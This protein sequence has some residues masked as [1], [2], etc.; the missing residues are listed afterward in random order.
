MNS[1]KNFN[2]DLES[3]MNKIVE[4]LEKFSTDKEESNSKINSIETF[5]SNLESKMNTIL[6]SLDKYNS[7][8]DRKRLKKERKKNLKE[9]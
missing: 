4:R 6:E 7:Y 5:N 3:K 8:Y 2:S 9:E 1:I